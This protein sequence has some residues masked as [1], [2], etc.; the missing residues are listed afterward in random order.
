M[1][2]SASHV[3]APAKMFRAA[4]AEPLHSNMISYIPTLL[5]RS[6]LGQAGCIVQ[7]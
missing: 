4:R 2:V 1:W 7:P 3:E 5:L 6:K